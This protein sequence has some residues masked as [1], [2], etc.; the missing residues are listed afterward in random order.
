MGLSILLT[1]LFCVSIAYLSTQF[2]KSFDITEEQINSLA[3]QTIQLLDKLE[4]DLYVKVFYKGRKGMES[5]ENVKR[6]LF[7]FKQTSSKVKDR[8]YNAHLE[9]T[10]A[11]QYLNDLSNKDKDNIFCIH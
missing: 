4:E 2:E 5:K 1:I 6:N 11:Q 8:Y 7:L 9:N 10:L 3:P